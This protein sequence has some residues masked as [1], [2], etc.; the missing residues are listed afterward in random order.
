MAFVFQYGSNTCPARLNSPE[1]LNGAAR[2]VG[3]AVTAE[4]WSLA[5]T[6]DSRVNRCA[7]ADLADVPERPIWGVVYDIPDRLLARETAAP[8]RAFDAIEG[9]YRR[10]PL[11]VR[12]RSENGELAVAREVITYRARKAV[13]GLLPSLAYVRWILAG[14][15]EHAA[16]AEY[17]E[18]VKRRAAEN[19]P[20]RAAWLTHE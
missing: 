12:L 8:H 13:A 2:V 5:F 1:R 4:P 18:Y 10:G 19:H 3:A 15:R 16:P 7:A 6:V 20:Q 9:N 14:L 17:L 11:L